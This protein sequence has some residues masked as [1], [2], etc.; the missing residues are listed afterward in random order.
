MRPSCHLPGHFYC[1]GL[2]LDLKQARGSC[3]VM[4]M[5]V[6]PKMTTERGCVGLTAG[7]ETKGQKDE[8]QTPVTL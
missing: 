4:G 6:G 8:L 2:W 1:I 7:I 3:E 5:L